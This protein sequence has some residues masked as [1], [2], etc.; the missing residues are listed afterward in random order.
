MKTYVIRF[1]TRDENTATD[2]QI[3]RAIVENGGTAMVDPN[4]PNK[5]P[6]PNAPD[7]ATLRHAMA[8]TTAAT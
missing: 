3:L 6:Y 2:D 4:D 8:G 5:P 1:G 7:E